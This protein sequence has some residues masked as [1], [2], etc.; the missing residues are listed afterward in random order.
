LGRFIALFLTA[1]FRAKLTRS[2]EIAIC[3]SNSA[4][5]FA[6]FAVFNGCFGQAMSAKI[7]AALEIQA[8][9]M[10]EG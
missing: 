4:P 7:S 5:F 3:F 2:H 6:Q 10:S 8:I 9:P 1:G